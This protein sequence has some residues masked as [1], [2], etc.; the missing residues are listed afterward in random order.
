MSLED[1]LV[2]PENTAAP[3]A[4]STGGW[5]TIG[6]CPQMASMNNYPV[7]MQ[8]GGV[9]YVISG[10]DGGNTVLTSPDDGV[11]WNPPQ[12]GDW[13]VRRALTGAMHAGK[14]YIVGGFSPGVGFSDTL[15]SDDCLHFT[16]VGSTPPPWGVRWAH[17]LLSTG[18]NLLM[19][20]GVAGPV[21]SNQVWSLDDASGAWTKIAEGQFK[22]RAWAAGAIVGSTLMVIGGWNEPDG[23]FAET[24]V[25]TDGGLNWAV[26]KAPFT[27]RHSAAA[28]TIGDTVYL[29]GGC[30][31]RPGTTFYSD[32][33]ATKD[34]ILWTQVDT[35][36]GPVG[37]TFAA[38][39]LGGKIGIMGTSPNIIGLTAPPIGWTEMPPNPIDITLQVSATGWLNGKYWAW[40]GVPGDAVWN[41]SDGYTW[42]PVPQVQPMSRLDG[43]TGTVHHGQLFACAGGG[44]AGT[45][46]VFAS[47]DGATWTQ[48]AGSQRFDP[49][50]GNLSLISFQ[51]KL[52][53]YGSNIDVWCSDD[54]GVSWTKAGSEVFPVYPSWPLGVVL[55]NKLWMVDGDRREVW[56]SPDGAD[57]TPQTNDPEW[58]QRVDFRLA[59]VGG[60]L[61][62]I[63]GQNAEVLQD[64]YASSDGVSWSQVDSAAQPPGLLGFCTLV[65]DDA[66]SAFGGYVGD[67]PTN[68]V[69]SYRPP[70]PPPA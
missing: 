67:Q 37:R 42:S 26:H 15:V 27:P 30:T 62:L 48:V 65:V 17:T 4:T 56:S 14:F 8:F 47:P 70:V 69:F 54:D 49:V 52:W 3:L 35:T 24:L 29:V 40:G 59:V 28:V 11:T 61:Y 9:T 20:A 23:A 34:G 63:R 43:N 12:T 41:S 13:P 39:D 7:A 45:N 25:S 64:I 36:F 1:T 2:R 22:P 58:T 50:P 33:W 21:Y 68:R 18:T 5:V 51:D 16:Q 57:W 6:T 46:D 53:L 19:I 31:G 55:Q 60:V 44:G 10:G 32:V 66:V 38:A